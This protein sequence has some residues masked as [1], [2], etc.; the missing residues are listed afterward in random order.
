MNELA[1]PAVSPAAEPG[2]LSSFGKKTVQAVYCA[3]LLSI[4]LETIVYYRNTDQ[5]DSGISLARMIGVLLFALA[6]VQWRS[7]FKKVPAA[8][9]MLAWYLTAFAL[10][11]L[12][13]PTHL[14]PKF[15]ELQTTLLQMTALFLVSYNLLRDEAFRTKALRLYGWWIVVIGLLMLLGILGVQFDSEARE[16]VAAQDPNVTAALLSLG[17]LCI[18]GDP[19][20]LSAKRKLA[21]VGASA[22]GTVILIGAILRTGSRGGLLA[23][24]GGV[25][26]LGLCAGKATRKAR[27][28]LMVLVLGM[29]AGLVAREFAL[30]T[31][32]AARLQRTWDEGD[33]AGRTII[34]DEAWAMFKE[35]PLQ[36]YGGANNRFVLGARLNYPDRDTHNSYLAVLTEVG[37]LGGIPFFLALFEALRRSWRRGKRVGD[38]LPFALMVSLLMINTSITGSREKIFWIVLAAAVAA[39]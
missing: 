26:A 38:A 28:V 33:T 27:V 22:L 7:C 9:W 5:P 24:G 6:F 14:D 2:R 30:G 20:L 19:L 11:Q 12:W 16:S 10:S 4:P 31:E 18:V 29:A 21:H 36:G 23:F 13:I 35:K 3:F 37:L 32:T 15:H 25:L 1:L 39:S 34:F 17:A 8:F